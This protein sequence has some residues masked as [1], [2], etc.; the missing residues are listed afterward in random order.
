MQYKKIAE[1][2]KERIISELGDKIDSIILY[3]S[4]A[5][6]EAKRES[7]IDILI[8]AHNDDKEVYDKISKIRT[9]IDLDN[10]TLTSLVYLSRKELKRYSKLGSPFIESIASEGVIL[11]DNGTFKGISKGLFAQGK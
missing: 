11:Y 1:E 4:V 7:D 9:S 2:L 3:G 8:V 5:R 6:G 10:N